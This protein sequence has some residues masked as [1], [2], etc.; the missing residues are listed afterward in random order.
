MWAVSNFWCQFNSSIDRAWSH[1]QDI[2]L[3]TPNA[4][5]SHRV[6][7]RVLMNG[8]KGTN[9]LTFELNSQ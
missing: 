3:A 6:E 1:N 5:L 9:R 8:W 4:F 2:W 7:Q